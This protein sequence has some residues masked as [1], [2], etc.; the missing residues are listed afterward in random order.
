MA[1]GHWLR[2]WVS[3][4]SELKAKATQPREQGKPFDVVSLEIVHKIA[5]GY[6]DKY[7]AC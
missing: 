5:A 3:P 2:G 1:L 4:T 6:L 7:V